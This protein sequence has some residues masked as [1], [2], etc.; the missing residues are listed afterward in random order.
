MTAVTRRAPVLPLLALLFAGVAYYGARGS[1]ANFVLSWQYAYGTNRGGVSLIVTASFLSI[2]AAQ[3]VGGR[4][5]ERM[6]AWKVLSAGLVLGVVGYGLGALVG[7]LSLE[8]LLV[9]I[10]AGFGGGLAANSTLSV[11]VTQLYRE[12]HGAL[13]GLIG[14]ATAA[15]SVVM[16]P[17]SR[18]AL[19]VS[20]KA[21]LLVLAGTIALALVA[22]LAFLRVGGRAERSKQA[23]VSIA[24]VMRHRDFWLLGT[25][26]FIC[27]V[28]ST[29]ITDT[30]LVAYMQGCHIGGGTAS[31]LAATL[32][33]FNLAGTF[34]SGLL[35]DRVDPRRLL[36]GRL[37]LPRDGAAAVASPALDRAPRRVLRDVRYRRLL[38]RPTDDGPRTAR[39]QGGRVRAR[40]RPDRRRAPG[41]ICGRQR[42]RR[43]SVRHDR[44]LRRVL[45]VSCPGLLPRRRPQSGDRPPSPTPA[46]FRPEAAGTPRG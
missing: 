11:M 3:I 7:T 34:G 25:P 13:F 15:G 29:G 44:G 10:V 33:L 40:A 9:G 6:D 26:F 8:I 30:H 17:V 23:P 28:T 32:A 42:A 16:L 21:A 41:R 35:T 12:R 5:L 22:V 2:G 36:A 1:L 46:G 43:L 45:R 37:R 27:G 31:T 38:D 24:S 14:A 4:L 19:D 18:I 39:V 20:L